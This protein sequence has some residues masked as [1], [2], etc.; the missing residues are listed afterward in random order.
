M[1]MKKEIWITAYKPNYAYPSAYEKLEDAL[2]S[3]D[4]EKQYLVRVDV[5]LP[6]DAE[7]HIGEIVD[8]KKVS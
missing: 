1:C 3:F 5:E 8:S 2:R 7:E 4:H 6:F